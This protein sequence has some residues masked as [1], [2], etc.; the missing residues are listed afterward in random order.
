M[1]KISFRR[2][3]DISVTKKVYFIVGTMAVLILVELLTLW[4]SIH[5]LSSVRALV[6]AEGLWSKAQK[7]AIYQLQKYYSSHDE[8]DYTAFKNF[9]S[10][11]LGDHKTRL[12]LIK[13]EPDYAIARQGFVEGKINPDDIEGIIQVLR[14]FH[15]IYYI[16]RAIKA[17]TDGDSIIAQLIPM[18][19]QLHNEINSA[20]PSK[21]KLDAIIKAIGPINHSLTIIEDDFS[22]IL[23]EGSRWLE[24]LILEILFIV[25]LTVEIT[26]LLLSISVSRSITKGLNEVN[27]AANKITQGDFSERAAVFSND[28]IGQVAMSVN[29][30]TEQLL[31]SNKELEQFAYI[32]SHDLQ[33]PLRMVTSF[34]GLLEAKYNDQLDDKGRRYI[35]LAVDG[36][37][38][39]RKIINDLLEYSKMARKDYDLEDV[40]MNTLMNDVAR[41]NQT[42]L[43]E[44]EVI[45]EWKDL[46]TIKAGRTPI[47]QVMHNLVGNAVKYRNTDVKPHIKIEATE[48]PEHWQFSVA[49]NGIGIDPMFYEKI[50]VLF[51]RLHNKTEY[52]GTGIGLSICKK[53][54]ENHKGNIWVESVPGKGSTFYF[55]IGK[56]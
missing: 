13:L 17:W 7:D 9:M 30:M 29:Q 19:E 55:T 42:R 31:K 4:F 21:E 50:F 8:Q 1:K 36:A 18:G 12:E 38:R 46:P 41:L 33:E 51:Q 52:S 37:E 34:L 24:N 23:G 27:R 15:N 39:M 47:F 43:K 48:T 5:T 45:L 11:P 16:K 10:V 3:K 35:N 28:E 44:N 26:G 40:D 56:Q 6:G 32:A 22:Y 25:A 54:I 49:D 53:I 14:R 2:L 20:A